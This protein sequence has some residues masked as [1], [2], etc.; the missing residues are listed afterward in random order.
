[1]HS[2]ALETRLSLLER[3]IGE[4]RKM[5]QPSHP[6]AELGLSSKEARSPMLSFE[7]RRGSEPPHTYGSVEAGD[8]GNGYKALRVC[9]APTARLDL[10]SGA[11]AL[12]QAGD[13]LHLNASNVRIQAQRVSLDGELSARMSTTEPFEW[14]SGEMPV[15]LVHHSHGIPVLTELKGKFRNNS[16]GI[17]MYV[18]PEDGYWYLTGD[19]S[20]GA[21]ISAR[22]VCIGRV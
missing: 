16:S 10:I 6:P 8:F 5:L 9:S 20:E 11:D 4:L 2:K 18:D 21:E 7:H 12:L 19:N 1:M 22:V 3:E 17:R 13:T 14:Q 15:R